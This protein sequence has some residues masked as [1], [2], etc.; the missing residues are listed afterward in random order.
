MTLVRGAGNGRRGRQGRW[1]EV[2]ATG[3]ADGGGAGRRSRRR[4]G[5]QRRLLEVDGDGDARK[6]AVTTRSLGIPMAYDD[7]AN[8]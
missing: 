7:P 6:G 1:P 2:P 3:S 8:R 5:Q 4:R